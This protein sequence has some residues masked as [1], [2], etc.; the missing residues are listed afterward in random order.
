MDNFTLFRMI[1]NK[2]TYHLSF[3]SDKNMCINNNQLSLIEQDQCQITYCKGCKTF[4]LVFNSC[5]ASFTKKELKQFRE[6]LEGLR[7]SDYQFNYMDNQNAIVVKPNLY[8]GFCLSREET[9][10][11]HQSIMEAETLFEAF[12]VIYN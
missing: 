10:L 12:G 9:Q 1:L 7:D 2:F 11:L 3:P 6:T 5:C 4:S 8:I